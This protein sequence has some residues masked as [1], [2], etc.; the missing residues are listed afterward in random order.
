[1]FL[2]DLLFAART[3]R[4]SPGFAAAAIGMLA[5][6]VGANTAIFSAI[7]EVLLRPLPVP[8]AGR[9]ASAYRFNVKT[10]RYLS[11]SYPVYEEMRQGARSFESLSAY[12]R[13]EF[14]LTVNGHAE[15]VPAEAVTGNYFDTMKL[16]PASGRA[17]RAADDAAVMLGEDLWHSRFAGDPSLIGR[18][19]LLEGRPFTVTGVVPRAF[20]GPNMNWG[21]PPQI[22]ITLEGAQL[23]VPAFRAI[24]IL[25]Q[26]QAEWL[27]V[28]GRLRPG[29]TIAQAQA[30]LRAQGHD[31]DITAAVFPASN[32]KFW[33]AYR[34]SIWRWLAV[35]GSAAGLVLLL[36]CANLSNLL[37]ERALGRRRE[38]AVRLALGAGTRR[39]ALQLLTENLLLAVPGFAAAIA[40]ALVLQKLMLG[41]PNAFGIALALDLTP[42]KRVLAFCFA[43]SLLA[44]V[45]FGLAPALSAARRDVLPALKESGNSSS[46]SGQVWL[47][48]G[49][50][51]A[52]VAF[53]MILLVC[54]GL[55][56]RSL[57]RAYSLDLGFRSDHLLS[58][59]FSLPLDY[60][61]DRAQKFYDAMLREVFGVRGVVSATYAA[62][63]PLSPVRSAGQADRLAVNYNMVGPEYLRTVG[64]TLLAGRDFDAHDGK[65]AARVAVVNQSLARS[66][67]G[68]ENALGRTIAFQDRPGRV[69][70]VQVVGVARDARYESVW[71][72]GEPY[73][74]LP[75]AEW[76]RPVTHLLVRTSGPPET[77]AA[78]LRRQ[79]EAVAP[80]A[81]AYG[82]K[83]GEELRAGAVAPQ[84]LA[85]ALLGAFGL[86]AILLAGVGLYS[87][88]AFSVGERTREIGIRLAIGARPAS[89]L[90]DVLADA[91][92]M[93][94]AGM[95]LGLAVS[96]AVMRLIAALVRDVSPYDG[97][98][99]ASVGLLLAVVAA[100]AALAPALRASRIDPARALRGE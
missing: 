42:E 30:E 66:L 28:I 59:S 16:A 75:A 90:R 77:F 15:R 1:M 31:R 70:A 23:L 63:M 36:A 32:A 87:V 74:Y 52:Q 18:T 73:L 50:V 2:Q 6:G 26:R 20:H 4:R 5:L 61:G 8:Q 40:V 89:V 53:S 76:Q 71:D 99:F 57:L 95:A 68:G 93:T 91:L 7:D 85:A 22:W 54:G 38:I 65:G 51:A 100:F 60:A 12:V 39:I 98:T 84:R 92:K 94:A 41:F 17:L 43:L 49:L 78:P 27:L 48:R 56:G 80:Q 83:T 9:L 44:S 37:L 64:I 3:L 14:N 47:R 82:M 29:A 69:T 21:D 25:H 97:L 35:F 58:M 86:L 11:T 67:W 33:P 88:V 62:E 24:D 19:V 10:G 79:W 81:P 13:L 34:S 55:F 96:L 45:L 72:A 46:A